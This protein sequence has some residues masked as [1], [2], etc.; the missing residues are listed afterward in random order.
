MNKRFNAVKHSPNDIIFTPKPV[1]LDMIEMAEITPNMRVLDP[2][3]GGGVFYDNLPECKKFYC[4]ITEGKDF[5]DFDE[6]V[7][8]VIGNPPFSL[9]DKFLTHTAKITDRFFYVMNIMNFSSKRIKL[10][11]ELGFGITFI[12]VCNVDWWF[13]ESFLVM[14]ERDA[15]S[16]VSYNPEIIFCDVCG[17]RCKRGRKNKDGEKNDPNTCTKMDKLVFF[18]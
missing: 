7:D 8:L 4:E 10:I 12:K 9:W 5:F 17:T 11:E 15:P 14:C 13:G 16:I 6:K 18:E 1:A 2:C 3:R